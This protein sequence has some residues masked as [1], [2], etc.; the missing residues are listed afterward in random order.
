[1]NLAYVG[2]KGTHLLTESYVNVEN[3]I[4]GLRPYPD[5]SQIPWRG[6]IGNSSYNAL[7][8]SLK[9][10]FSRGLLLSANYTWSHEIDDGSNGS[11]DG[12]SLTPQNVSCF[13]PGVP[14]C[15]ERASGAFDARNVF[16]ANVVYELPFG[17]GKSYLSQPGLMRTVFGSWQ[18][19][20]IVYA[21]TGF[22][23]SLTTSATGPDGN[24]NEQRPNLVPGQP[25]YLGGSLNP[26]AFCT[27]G[28]QDPLYP[29][30][31][32]PAGFGNVP[33]NI[34][35]GPGVWQTDLALS[36]RLPI[37]EQ[38]QVQFR[39]EV[40]NVFNSAQFANPNGL[41][42]ASDF[43]IIYL[44]LN[45]TP[46]GTGTPRQFQFLLKLQF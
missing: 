25:L 21:R 33:R 29:G 34:L 15:G 36:K 6:S 3:P 30:G 4:S 9:R 38:L 2:T 20:G 18:V 46:I 23:T 37:T 44:P 16:N 8:V 32:C 11:G 17:V 28:T 42:S 40:F 39:A 24:T 22:P 41:I 35:R 26:G 7:A 19:S 31:T 1:M 27:P 43:G 5:F 14:A 13:P 45:T 10:N 12:D